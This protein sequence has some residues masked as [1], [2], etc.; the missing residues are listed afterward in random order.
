MKNHDLKLRSSV[1]AE[2]DDGIPF[3][4]LC[5]RLQVEPL[6]NDKEEL[7]GGQRCLGANPGLSLST[8]LASE[9]SFDVSETQFPL[10]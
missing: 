9:E 4:S 5:G 2:V 6:S 7:F 1:E 8:S 10:L 3:W